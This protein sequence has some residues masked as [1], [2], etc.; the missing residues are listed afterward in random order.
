MS[1]D[2]ER[3]LPYSSSSPTDIGVAGASL[4]TCTLDEGMTDQANRESRTLTTE[5]DSV[6]TFLESKGYIDGKPTA[7]GGGGGGGTAA[8]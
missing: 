3:D 7:T 6:L 2:S 1:A 5:I 8:P 4:M